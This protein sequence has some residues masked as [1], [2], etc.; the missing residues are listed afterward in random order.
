MAFYGPQ[1][2]KDAIWN[3]YVKKE[4]LK[5]GIIIL[6]RHFEITFECKIYNKVKRIWEWPELSDM[7]QREFD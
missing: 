7:V 6:E 5:G 2:V 3:Q 4:E 1:F